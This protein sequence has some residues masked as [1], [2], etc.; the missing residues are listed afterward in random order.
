LIHNIGFRFLVKIVE[1]RGGEIPM[2]GPTI[3]L[4]NHIRF[5]DPVVILANL[6]RNTVPLAKVKP[7]A[8]R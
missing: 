2:T 8:T 3:V 4:Y 1:S 7:T 6:P 5:V